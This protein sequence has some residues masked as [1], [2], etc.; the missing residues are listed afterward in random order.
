M[1]REDAEEIIGADFA[2]L[3]GVRYGLGD[4]VRVLDAY[5]RGLIALHSA[6][7]VKNG[8]LREISMEV[9]K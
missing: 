5:C 4:R 7:V 2:W 1:N 8:E 6:I 9:T 3:D